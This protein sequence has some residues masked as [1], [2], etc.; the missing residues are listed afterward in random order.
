MNKHMHRLVFDRRRGMRVAAAETARSAGKAASGAT[1]GVVAALSAACVLTA[2]VGT[3]WAQSRSLGSVISRSGAVLS[4]RGLAGGA[5]VPNLPVASRGVLPV[6]PS[7]PR[8]AVYLAAQAHAGQDIGSAV[9]SQDG[10]QMLVKQN[11]QKVK[12]NWE[13]FDIG[14]GYSV[15]FEQPANGTAWNYVWDANPSVI[16]GHLTATGEVILENHNGVIFSP[17]ARIETARFVATALHLTQDAFVRAFKALK[18]FTPERPFYPWYYRILRNLCLSH[19]ERHGPNRRVSLEHLVEEEHVQFEAPTEDVVERIHQEEM[20]VHLR[21]ALEKL[22]PEFKEIIAM[23]HF[24]EMSY[25]E[26][27]QAL[28]IPIGTVMSRLHRGRERM[29]ELMTSAGGPGLRRVK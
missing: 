25:E 13:T 8:Y 16:Q 12:I 19:M 24:E 10:T 5:P 21:R 9:I 15:H 6:D 17:T 1:P 2:P 29:R 11:D 23:K 3:A 14:K 28:R 18:K 27:A 26:I 4:A 22:K 7:D 20:A